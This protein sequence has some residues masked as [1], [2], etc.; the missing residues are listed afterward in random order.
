[1]PRKEAM[2]TRGQV[3]AYE[4]VEYFVL[5]P[6][7]VW[8]PVVSTDFSSAKEL[9]KGDHL[10]VREPTAGEQE[11]FQAR[12]EGPPIGSEILFGRRTWTVYATREEY[13]LVQAGLHLDEVSRFAEFR[14]RRVADP[15]TSSR[16]REQ[17]RMPGN[18][19]LIRLLAEDTLF[20]VVETA[21][22]VE[23][24][25]TGSTAFELPREEPLPAHRVIEEREEAVAAPRAPKP[26]KDDLLEVDWHGVGYEL[27]PRN[28]V[29]DLDSVLRLDPDLWPV[30]ERFRF[31]YVK[32]PA[33]ATQFPKL[34]QIVYDGPHIRVWVPGVPYALS[35]PLPELGWSTLAQI[36]GLAEFL[37][38]RCEGEV[39]TLA[40]RFY[41]VARLL[42]RKASSAVS[43]ATSLQWGLEGEDDGSYRALAGRVAREMGHT[44]EG[45]RRSARAE[46]ARALL[47]N[48]VADTLRQRLSPQP[49]NPCPLALSCEDEIQRLGY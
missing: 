3:V 37:R 4:G 29:G 30:P 14:I 25:S 24:I 34:P 18:G 13:L 1:M 40:V 10:T 11:A 36:E 28:L 21:S 8:I 38:Q 48:T 46:E 12:L 9:R 16:V 39:D 17:T 27:R 26:A 5:R 7:R 47:H 41:F 33:E 22:A 43:F 6:K 44:A 19:A 45:V 15:A 32:V 35:S 49:L 20:R 31:H 23:L 42:E 2:P